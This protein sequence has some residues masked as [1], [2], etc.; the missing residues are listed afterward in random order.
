MGPAIKPYPMTAAMELYLIKY[1]D[2]A[3]LSHKRHHP[4]LPSPHLCHRPFECPHAH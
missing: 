4:A 2:K 1:V 3:G